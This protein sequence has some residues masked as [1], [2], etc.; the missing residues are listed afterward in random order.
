MHELDIMLVLVGALVVSLGLLSGV[1]EQHLYFSGTLVAL[2][3]GVLLGPRVLNWLDPARWGDT[4][5]LLEGAARLTLGMTLMDVA[6]RLPVGYVERHWRTLALFYGVVTPLMWLTGG[7]LLVAVLPIP[8][9]MAM[10]VGGIVAPTDPVVAGAIVTGRT[11]EQS[12]PA[13]LRHV[14]AAESAGNDGLA[15]PL[16]MLSLLLATSPRHFSL[17]DWLVRVVLWQIGGAVAVGALLGTAAGRLLV[18]S[19]SERL[20]EH[21]WRLAYAGGLSLLALGTAKLLGTDGVLA[22]LA[23]GLALRHATAHSTGVEQESAQS[24]LSL[25]FTLSLFALLGLMLPWDAWLT[26]G[27]RS[28]VA[29][30]LVVLFRRL[31]A[32]LTL[33]PIIRPF[34]RWA[35]ALFA[36]WFGPIGVGAVFYATL[37]L[38]RGA[39]PIVWTLSSLAVV[40]SVLVHGVSATPLLHLYR[41]REGPPSGTSSDD[42]EPSPCAPS[43]SVESRAQAKGDPPSREV[44]R[45]VP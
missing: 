3:A 11:A 22:P 30:L 10:L 1:I 41:R 33:K 15:Y 32:V 31:P 23:A 39:P 28:W 2:A 19:A 17:T 18:R 34:R 25:F 13:R 8:F 20:M 24:S 44:A 38:G 42:A 14:I 29:V 43:P 4:R 40:G 36:G 27:W 16:V 7:L 21:P 35:D 26:L 6:L 5:T 9:W 45:R 12:L 37:A